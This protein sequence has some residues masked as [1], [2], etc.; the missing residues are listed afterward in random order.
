MRSLAS[1]QAALW[2]ANDAILRVWTKRYG[3]YQA[4]SKNENEAS[5]AAESPNQEPRIRRWTSASWIPFSLSRLWSTFLIL[6][7]GSIVVKVVFLRNSAYYG[8][9]RKARP[10]LETAISFS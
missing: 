2:Q 3:S 9:L 10:Y 6:I 5:S 4:L 7:L 1:L 8:I